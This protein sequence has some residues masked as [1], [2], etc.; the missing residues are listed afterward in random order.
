MIGLGAVLVDGSKKPGVHSPR[1]RVRE[2]VKHLASGMEKL[3]KVGYLVKS[4][5]GNTRSEARVGF[6]ERG[7]EE[8]IAGGGGD[9][10][11]T[12][13]NMDGADEHR[14][15][16]GGGKPTLKTELVPLEVYGETY[17]GN[18]A[19]SLSCR[20]SDALLHPRDRDFTGAL[21]DFE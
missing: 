14:P 2:T 16:G 8:H 12:A 7:D 6:A 17:P 18:L 5:Y 1:E 15:A 21:F 19:K 20:A 4:V 3:A 13:K 9:E 11:G 10:V